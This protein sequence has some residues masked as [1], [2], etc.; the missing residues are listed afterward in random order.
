MHPILNIATAAARKAGNTMLRSLERLDTI[1]PTAKG[2]NDFVTDVDKKAEQ[3][4]IAIIKKAHPDHQIIA[5]E[6]GVHQGNADCAWIIDPLDGTYNYMR[7]YPHFSVS[8]AFRFRGKIEQGLVYDPIRQEIFTASR[9]E[10]ARLNDRRIRVSATIKLA[11]AFLCTGFPMRHPDELPTNLA[12]FQQIMLQI[13]KIRCAGS[14]ALDLAYVAA[15]RLDGYFERNLRVWDI[16][17]GALLVK[18]AGGLVSDWKGA[19]DYLDS[20]HIIAATPKVFSALMPL[21]GKY[22]ES[23]TK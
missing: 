14:A 12:F 17:A 19:E 11:N 20:G 15:G 16:A 9:G 23:G 2:L 7:G 6:S 8:I 1:N 13:S 4:I 21:V 5:E 10:G 18:E 3:E 22:P